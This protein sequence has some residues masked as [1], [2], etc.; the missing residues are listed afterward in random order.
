MNELSPFSDVSTAD[1]ALHTA[2]APRH[3]ASN[4]VILTVVLSVLFLGYLVYLFAGQLSA[5]KEAE[6][7]IAET[8]TIQ[9]QIS[10][11]QARKVSFL[12]NAKQVLDRIDAGRIYWSKVINDALLIIPKDAK[13]GSNKAEFLTYSGSTDGKLVLSAKTF[14]ASPNPYLDIADVV[15]AFNKSSIFRDTFV[16]TISKNQNEQGQTVLTFVLNLTYHGK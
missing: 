4:F 7:Y 5:T 13:S 10:A 6:G 1:A 12:Q 15:T 11:L 3:P 8:K 14:N 16:P 9:Q 2:D